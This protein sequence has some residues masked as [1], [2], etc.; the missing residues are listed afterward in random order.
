M[1]NWMTELLLREFGA[2]RCISSQGRSCQKIPLS[3]YNELKVQITGFIRFDGF[4]ALLLTVFNKARSV[5]LLVSKQPMN[6]Y[7]PSIWMDWTSRL[8]NRSFHIVQ[9]YK[10]EPGDGVKYFLLISISFW[11]GQWSWLV[12]GWLADFVL[13]N[14]LILQL[15]KDINR[16]S[17]YLPSATASC[18]LRC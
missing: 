7:V 12:Y 15:L 16:Q 17:S 11:Q 6:S 5:S 1:W 3:F 14:C 8:G 10:T 9:G 4:G 2:H 13:D 18:L